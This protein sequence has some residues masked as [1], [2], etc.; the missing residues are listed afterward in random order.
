MSDHVPAAENAATAKAVS[1]TRNIRRTSLPNGMLVLTE[2]MP[3][4]RSVSMG[5]WI[6]SGSRDEPAAENGLSHF[7]EHMVFKGT[8]SRS[9]QDIAREVDSIGGNLDAFTGKESVC[10]NIKVLDENMA[11]ALDVLS[12]LVLHPK[13]SQADLER[14][15]GVILEEIKM[16]EDNPDYLVH[17]TF[18]Q[19]FWKNH[20]LGRPILGTVK[21]VSSFDQETVFDHHRRRFTPENMVFS[22]AG[23]LNHDAFIEAVA[24]KF[25][26]LE[27]G[28]GRA[29]DQET[30][31]VTTAHIT[32]KKKKSLEQVQMCLGMPAPPVAD[33]DRFAIY[34]LNSMLGGGMSSRLFESIRENEG[35]AYSIYSELSPFR[36]AGALSI[37][38]G[39]S[40][41]KS[42]RVIDLTMVEL[43]KL[44]TERV[45]AAE[46]KRAKDQMK[47]NIVLGL[48]SSS[49]RMSNLA[50]QQIYFGRFF[51]VDEVTAEI[52]RVTP[53]EIQRLAKELFDPEK[54]ALTLLGNLGAMKVERDRLA[55]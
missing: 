1:P 53:E 28:E 20:P 43:R 2:Q 30:T 40:L 19:N 26:G 31:P 10:F 12:D 14:E 15:Q 17:E 24:A 48:E 27:P 25:G 44:K 23:N 6:A 36:D 29:V 51:S 32:L 13:F 9:A 22:A 34:M 4:M 38:A 33:G 7:V 55:C 21:T 42:D 49:S 50:R 39:M 18:T 11:P 54:I 46:L 8:T 16:D 47:S 52:D 37:Y 41:D 5:A 35:L 45:S 3:H